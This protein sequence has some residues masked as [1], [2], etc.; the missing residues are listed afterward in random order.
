MRHTEK[1]LDWFARRKTITSLEAINDL[2]IHRL[3]AR[4][5]E[6]RQDGHAIRTEIITTRNRHGDVCHPARYHYEGKAA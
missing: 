3:G 5:L 6:L 2:G 1:L 4:I